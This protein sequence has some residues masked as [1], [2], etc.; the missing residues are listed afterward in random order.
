MLLI[1]CKHF[2]G[3]D[4]DKA[5]DFFLMLIL[6]YYL[7]YALMLTMFFLK[8]HMSVFFFFKQLLSQSRV[9]KSHFWETDLQGM[10]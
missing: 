6:N 4:H 3:Y 7:F 1:S 2:D 5:R 8:L 9:P 10:S